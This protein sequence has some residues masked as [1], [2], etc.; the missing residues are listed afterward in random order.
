MTSKAKILD[1]AMNLNRIGNWA[2]DDYPGKKERIKTFL[3][4]T[5]SYLESLKGNPLPSSLE[6]TIKTFSNEYYPLL[7]EGLTG[8]KD[9]IFWAE[10]MMT[11]GNILTHRS[12]L[13][14]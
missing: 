1:I 13:A 4:S 11:W 5:S 7:D 10:K 9:A 8:P 2:A 12:Q 3:L 14:R 6:K